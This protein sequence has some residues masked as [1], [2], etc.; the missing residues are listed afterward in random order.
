[1]LKHY[2][3]IENV[4]KDNL[5]MGCGVCR[6]ICPEDA[7]CMD[8]D[9]RKGYFIPK[10]DNK[11]CNYCDKMKSGKCVIVCPGLEVD[12]EKLGHHWIDGNNPTDILGHSARTVYTHAVD[13][14]V[15]YH[16]SSG[17]LVT[18]LL[19]FLLKKKMI[20]GAIVIQSDEK[21]P[22]I[23]KG[24]LATSPRE[25]VNA[26][27]SKYCSANIGNPLS[28]ILNKNGIF[29]VV[30]L[31]CHI[32]G[33]RK[34]E[35][36]HPRISEKIVYHFGLYCA[37]NNTRYGT[38]YFLRTHKMVP[39]EVDKLTYRGHGWPGKLFVELKNGETKEIKRG[40]TEKSLFK[41][42]KFSS[43]FH[44]DFQIPRCVTCIDLT[45][46]LA[47]I[48]FAD[49]WNKR[50][51]GK[52]TIGKSMLVIRNQKGNN[53]IRL[54]EEDGIIKIEHADQDEVRMSQNLTFKNKAPSRVW[55]RKMLG[56]PSPQY[57]GKS[58]P[59]R[60]TDIFSYGNYFMSWL[61]PSPVF[62]FMLPIV[63][64]S[65]WFVG[66]VLHLIKKYLRKLK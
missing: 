64:I 6:A 30:G 1:M 61:T 32:Q 15:R 38:E 66:Q 28:E 27:G 8:M 11:S 14:S 2:Q 5:C 12:F 43:S 39:S 22:L 53:L 21:N 57:K 3:T 41:K 42:L 55:F 59:L 33:I 37:N 44:Y 58:Y 62:R 51:M 46:E 48:S 63:Q 36:F 65:R 45:A 17:G 7:I 18:S 9:Q 24:V 34:W 4:V 13:E 20:D 26:S 56:F 29:A 31:P 19:V 16:S 10:I 60:L 52:E 49:P 50:F 35:Q 40:T 23:P 25:I 54:A 47:D